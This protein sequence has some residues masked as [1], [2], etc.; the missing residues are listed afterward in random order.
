MTL[1]ACKYGCNTLIQWDTQI[2]AFKEED[3]TLHNRARCESLRP[4]GAG[5]GM[6]AAAQQNVAKVPQ[7][8]QQQHKQVQQQPVTQV[9][10]RYESSYLIPRED[11]NTLTE[12][13]TKITMQLTHLSEFYDGMMNEIE[14]IRNLVYQQDSK[15]RHDQQ[16]KLAAA[17][18]QYDQDK[19]DGTLGFV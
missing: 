2:N 16:Q 12:N 11:W 15:R 14:A 1:K 10:T 3:G 17:E 6:S 5:G 13:I 9:P 8:Q 4:L 19:E 7:P 18:E